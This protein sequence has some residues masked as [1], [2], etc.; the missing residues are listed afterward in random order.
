MLSCHKTIYWEYYTHIVI[1]Q[2]RTTSIL[3]HDY[4][5]T[6]TW[7]QAYCHMTTSKSI[8][9]RKES[10][11]FQYTLHRHSRES[12]TTSMWANDVYAIN[13]SYITWHN[14]LIARLYHTLERS[15]LSS[16]FS[17]VYYHTEAARL[18]WQWKSSLKSALA[19]KLVTKTKGHKTRDR[20][21]AAAYKKAYWAA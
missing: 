2:T 19:Q 3:P 8:N 15:W 10:I 21:R 12:N 20:K 18:S 5:H 7:L 16:H 4:K 11:T 13:Y 17:I 9:N 14:V 6:V 1:N